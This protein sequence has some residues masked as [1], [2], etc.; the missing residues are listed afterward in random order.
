[1]AGC[2]ATWLAT[3]IPGYACSTEGQNDPKS[4]LLGTVWLFK[5]L[6]AWCLALCMKMTDARRKVLCLRSI[7]VAQ[8]TKDFDS[9]D[10]DDTTLHMRKALYNH[11]PLKHCACVLGRGCLLSLLSV[12][13]ASRREPSLPY[14]L[15]SLGARLVRP[16]LW[17]TQIQCQHCS[18]PI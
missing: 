3:S 4:W 17:A 8:T 15:R 5:S 7:G 13:P 14:G 1:M 16:C 10:S 2:L 18:L 11:H 9:A 12:V 6:S